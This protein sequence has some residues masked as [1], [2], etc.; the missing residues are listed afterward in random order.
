VLELTHQG[1]IAVVTMS[2]GKANA[3]DTEFCDALT[4]R[5]DDL[6]G[7]QAK[8][9]VLTG[10]GRIFSA[11]VDLLRATSSGPDYFATFLPALSRFYQTAFFF[12]KPVVAAIN[13]HAVAGGCVLAC[14]ADHRVMARGGGRI[15]VTELQVGLPFPAMAFEIMRFVT[16]RRRL[17]EVI[18]GAATYAPEDARER[19]LVDEVAAPNDLLARALETAE[20]LAAL[21]P[22]AFELAKGHI[23]G[24]V[25]EK[26]RRDGSAHDAAVTALWLAPDTAASIRDYVAR[27]FKRP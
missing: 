19:G 14:C 6:R 1:A 7:S 8:A 18:L 11:G 9:V 3:L 24:P 21:R 26:F 25:L 15:G 16:A 27:T 17:S 4:A 2:H 12:P 22:Q 13:G 10:Q 23:R 20:R 5:F